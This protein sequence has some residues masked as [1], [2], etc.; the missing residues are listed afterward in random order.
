MGRKLGPVPFLWEGGTGS[1][2]TQCRLGQ[3]LSPY[4]VAS[5]SIQPFGHNRHRPKLGAPSPFWEGAGSPSNTI[6][7]AAAYLPTKWH[8]DASSRLATIE[9]GQKLGE[10]FCPLPPFWGG[11]AGF[12]SSTMWPGPRAISMPS[13]IL[14]H[15]AVCHNR[16]G[17]KIGERAPP[18]FAEGELGSRLTQCHLDR[19][20]PP[21]QVA[22]WCIQPFDHNRHGPKIGRDS[23]PF[24][25][26]G[27]GPHVRQSPG[28]RPT[29]IPSGILMHQTVWLWQQ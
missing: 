24:C 9:M 11:G 26:K 29:S 25:G 14:I 4:Q 13:A 2:V 3:G 18:L 22:S 28:L 7:W 10:G 5:W 19:G 12:P 1:H 21:Y 17:P 27:L 20:L 6:A 8:L 16:N 15:P 23:A